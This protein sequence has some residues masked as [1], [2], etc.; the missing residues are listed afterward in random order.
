M[1][2]LARVLGDAVAER[3][4]PRG[5]RLPAARGRPGRCSRSTGPGCGRRCARGRPSRCRGCPTRRSGCRPG[6][7]RPSRWGQ[8]GVEV[9]EGV[10][11]R[12]HVQRSHLV[13]GQLVVE[14]LGHHEVAPVDATL[15]VAV[16]E[17][18]L[19]AGGVAVEDAGAEGV[20]GLG[21]DDAV[22]DLVVGHAGDARDLHEGVAVAGRGLGAAAAVVVAEEPADA[23]SSSSSPELPHAAKPRLRTQSATTKRRPRPERP[24][25]RDTCAVMASPLRCRPESPPRNVTR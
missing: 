7:G 19:D 24:W 5:A 10:V 11:G 17:V 25:E 16:R 14:R 3:R 12:D 22:L 4:D 2:A 9:A 15:A 6:R 8:G 23:P 21:A 20:V 1:G 18:G 13:V